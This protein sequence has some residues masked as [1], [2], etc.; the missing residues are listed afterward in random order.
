MIKMET[1]KIKQ[2]TSRIELGHGAYLGSFSKSFKKAIAPLSEVSKMRGLL[3]FDNSISLE[4]FIAFS[5][6]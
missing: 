6:V 1:W 5:F 4:I 2:N 3:G